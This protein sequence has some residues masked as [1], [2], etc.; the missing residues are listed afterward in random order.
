MPADDRFGFDDHERRPP[1]PP[2][3]REP[4][5]E[6]SVEPRHAN[7]TRARSLKDVELVPECEDFE[8]QDR[9]RTTAISKRREERSETAIV[10]A[11]YSGSDANCNGSNKNDVF[12]RDNICVGDR[13][14][15]IVMQSAGPPVPNMGPIE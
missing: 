6:H 14:D 9:P 15:N 10:P 4:D 5:P 3:S 11:A 1:L 8:L 2:D 7:S 13:V 12:G